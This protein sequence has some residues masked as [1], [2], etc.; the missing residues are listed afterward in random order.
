MSTN[1][2]MQV[3]AII[4]IVAL[5]AAAVYL[6]G[7]VIREQ[8]I[9]SPEP[10]AVLRVIGAPPEAT[11]SPLPP[12]TVAP[13]QVTPVAFPAAGGTSNI[14]VEFIMDASG[15][16]MGQLPD[17]TYKRDAAREA[18]TA[19]LRVY[20]PEI[21]VGLRA[22]GHNLNWQGGNEEASCRDIEL[23]APVETGQLERIAGWRWG[24]WWTTRR[25]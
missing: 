24:T 19:R 23:I 4:V 16:M 3:I 15:S 8:R 12:A 13:V 21:Q 14:Y 6:A 20:Q 7:R 22:Y 18:M 1:R 10:T 25:G 5:A 17:G 2:I 11:T 9:V